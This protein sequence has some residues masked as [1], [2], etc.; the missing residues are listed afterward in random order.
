[1]SGYGAAAVM[2]RDELP[3]DYEGANIHRLNKSKQHTH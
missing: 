1:M 2:S 3:Q